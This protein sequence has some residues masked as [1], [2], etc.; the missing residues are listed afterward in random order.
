MACC[1]SKRSGRQRGATVALADD[2]GPGPFAW[3]GDGTDI[4]A[5]PFG[6]GCT[7][8]IVDD[9]TRWEARLTNDS[10]EAKLFRVDAKS[11]RSTELRTVPLGSDAWP[12]QIGTL[13]GQGIVGWIDD[14]VT[15]EQT[16]L[17]VFLLDGST[18]VRLPKLEPPRGFKLGY[19]AA[20]G[21]A[22]SSP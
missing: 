9:D 16:G 22:Q 14:F 17:V 3:S 19:I 7:V 12:S 21:R 13:K 2:C 11:G 20:A 4:V 8:T 18:P 10:G 5:L 15:F 6:E 1:L